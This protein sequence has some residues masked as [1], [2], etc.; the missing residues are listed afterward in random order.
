MCSVVCRSVLLDSQVLSKAQTVTIGLKLV[1]KGYKAVAELNSDM[2]LNMSLGAD[3]MPVEKDIELMPEERQ[4]L[5]PVEVDIRLMPEEGQNLMPVEVDFELMPE[6]ECQ[7]WMPGEDEW[8][9][10]EPVSSTR[11]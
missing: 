2:R 7:R 1:K 3:Q 4:S 6:K 8:I 9:E 11:R 5:M 10:E